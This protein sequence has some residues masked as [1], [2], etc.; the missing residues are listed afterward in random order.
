MSG[1]HEL[2]RRDCATS[3]S[4]S[5][6]LRP[7]GRIYVS[8]KERC[9]ARGSTRRSRRYCGVAIVKKSTY[10]FSEGVRNPPL[11]FLPR[12]T[13]APP[14]FFFFSSCS[15]NPPLSQKK[16]NRLL[17]LPPTRNVE[18]SEAVSH[19]KRE[20][21]RTQFRFRFV[22]RSRVPRSRLPRSRVPPC[23][24]C[25]GRTPP[26]PLQ[27]AVGPSCA[28]ISLYPTLKKAAAILTFPPFKG[29][30]KRAPQD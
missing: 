21:P 8:R 28:T 23:V 6:P 17:F 22:L 7:R 25:P 11:F 20:L 27:S 5:T 29:G 4:A 3:I 26:S 9:D 13:E 30:P 14:F 16:G 10:C 15:E 1:E 24:L 2:R 12:G 18:K 19:K